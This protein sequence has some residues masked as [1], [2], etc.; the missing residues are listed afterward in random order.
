MFNRLYE[1]FPSAWA[2]DKRGNPA[3]PEASQSNI[4]TLLRGLGE[5]M[6]EI[7]VDM[8]DD[9]SGLLIDNELEA[10]T[11]TNHAVLQN[12]A[13]LYGID[14][15]RFTDNE[16]RCL[17][18]LRRLRS[19]N[20]FSL[21]L[22]TE[23]EDVLKK[24]NIANSLDIG[25]SSGQPMLGVDY[26]DA[27]GNPVNISSMDGGRNMLGGEWERGTDTP[28][29]PNRSAGKQSPLRNAGGDIIDRFIPVRLGQGVNILIDYIIGNDKQH[30]KDHIRL[31]FE[32]F[33]P[34]LVEFNLREV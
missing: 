28:G 5:F 6:D 29:N 20:G 17:I 24:Y 7:Y 31:I 14:N 1:L 30:V 26:N 13:R 12:I 23:A 10:P 15:T 33:V 32:E 27:D 3:N 18:S 34:V 11:T 4:E 22:L 16:L 19:D 2:K 8:I 21:Q 9:T 25:R